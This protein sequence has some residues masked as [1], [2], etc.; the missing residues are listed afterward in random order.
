MAA[1]APMQAGAAAAAAESMP[2][3]PPKRSHGEEPWVEKHRPRKMCDV[4]GNE[5]TVARLRVIARDGNMPNIIITGPPGT[6]KTTSI[7]AMAH[8][9]LGAKFADAVLELNAS[10]E[11]GL[12]V[13]RE[14]IKAFAQKKVTLAP[15]RTKIII[16]D[17]ADAMTNSAQQAMRRIMEVHSGTT[18]FALACNF[19][20][21]IIE[22]IQSR[23][24]VLRFGRLDN[25]DVHERLMV[26]VKAEKVNI[27]DDGIEAILYVA[28]GDLRAAINTLQSCAAGFT[29]VNAEAVFKV[30]DQPHPTVVEDV[31]R[32][33]AK[34]NLNEAHRKLDKLLLG[35][36]YA[37]IDIVST[38]FK[39]TTAVP[40]LN[41]QL[42]LDFVRM[43]G[44]VHHRMVEG[45]ATPL[46]LGGLLARLCRVAQPQAGKR[47]VSA[48]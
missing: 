26:V 33:C 44:T 23:C 30:V 17:E 28:E 18:R 36:G 45:C 31:I 39:V 10:D 8:E 2:P 34:G 12:D 22:P 40:G 21:K 13:V 19:S 43:I 25:V 1:A 7:S 42:Q 27:T 29:V 5:D 41:E 15:G 6:G 35:K 38:F 24:A 16:L 9:L 3:P 46:Q 20:G 37:P 11:R 48:P 47:P 14:R 32:D 4:V